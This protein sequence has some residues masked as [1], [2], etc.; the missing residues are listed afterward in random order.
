[1]LMSIWFEGSGEIRCGIAD[2]KAA[3]AD[4]GAYYVGVVGL[5]P[6]LSSVE[7]VEQGADFVTI[8]THEGL[9]KRTGISVLVEAERV[10]VELD[11]EYLAGRMITARGHFVDE[12][13]SSDA[14]VTHRMVINSVEAPGFLGFFYRH[15]ASSSIG[16]AF[17]KSVKAWFEGR[18]EAG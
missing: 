6:G 12:F 8:R 2:V 1:M 15:L 13:T 16:K 18:D 3:V 9:M 7:L 5:M 4:L 11:E 17:L 14:G 10:V